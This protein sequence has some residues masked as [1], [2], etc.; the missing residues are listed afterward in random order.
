MSNDRYNGWTNYETWN[1]ALWIDNDEYLQCYYA[2]KAQELLDDTAD[3]IAGI[4]E[5]RSACVRELAD[6]IQATIEDSQPDVPNSV[7]LDLLTHALGRVEWREIA[8]HYLADVEP[9]TGV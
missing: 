2:D 5:R 9:S 1:V 4:E 8:E 3:S 6:D 7:Y